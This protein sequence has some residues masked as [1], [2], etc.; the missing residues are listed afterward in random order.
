MCY[1][2]HYKVIWKD[3]LHLICDI[4][5]TLYKIG[6]SDTVYGCLLLL[7]ITEITLKR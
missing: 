5:C 4:S 6:L 2:N 3:I 7:E 1:I